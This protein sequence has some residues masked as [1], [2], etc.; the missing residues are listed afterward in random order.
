MSSLMP[1]IDR[2]WPAHLEPIRMHFGPV[3]VHSRPVPKRKKPAPVRSSRGKWRKTL[4][5]KKEPSRE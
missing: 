5:V 4:R 3:P 2:E 1:E